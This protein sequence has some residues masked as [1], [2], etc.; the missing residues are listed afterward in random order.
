VS[1]DQIEFLSHLRHFSREKIVCIPVP[2]N[3]EID[4][5]VG[6]RDRSHKVIAFV[7]RIQSERNIELFISLTKYFLTRDS[8]ISVY[9]IGDGPDLEYMK[10]EFRT[11]G[12]SEI[13]FMGHLSSLDLDRI[14]KRIGVLISTATTE[15]YGRA[16]REA[17]CHGT[18]V[19]AIESNGSA[20]LKLECTSGFELFTEFD[21]FESIYNKLE[22]LFLDK[23]NSQ[24]IESQLRID[25]RI[26]K[27]IANSWITMLSDES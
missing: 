15:S 9:V 25:T 27:D 14:W 18:S 23:P 11:I 16:M 10:S 26:P 20:R 21:E 13:V 5:S 2:L 8:A 1:I 22:G 24:F 12:N 7:G 6:E 19:L 4:T 17:L 3:G